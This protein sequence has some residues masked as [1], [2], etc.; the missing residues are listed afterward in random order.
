MNTSF[1][2]LPLVNTYG[3]FG[4]VGRERYEMKGIAD[5]LRPRGTLTV[6]AV[7]EDGRAV[8]FD[9]SRE[10]S[11]QRICQGRPRRI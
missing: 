8:Q 6:R 1:T 4:S 11:T 10:H 9:A 3:A 5:G 2:R 7:G